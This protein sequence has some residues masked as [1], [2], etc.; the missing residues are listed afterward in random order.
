MADAPAA[1]FAR[2]GTRKRAVLLGCRLVGSARAKPPPLGGW[3]FTTEEAT[4]ESGDK[5]R[6]RTIFLR[7][8]R[9][10]SDLA[11]ESPRDTRQRVA[12]DDL[13]PAGVDPYAHLRPGG[14]PG[15]HR[16]RP[17]RR[18]NRR[19]GPRGAHPLVMEHHRWEPDS[20]RS[21]ARRYY[22]SQALVFSSVSQ[23]LH[24]WLPSAIRAI[25][26]CSKSGT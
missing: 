24:V 20:E 14:A 5:E 3:W 13:M 12:Q 1:G 9:L 4:P 18:E 11:A 8:T 17:H 19:S 22:G 23:S 16:R 21:A 7:L 10:D 26:R 2:Q 15:D 6:L 25:T